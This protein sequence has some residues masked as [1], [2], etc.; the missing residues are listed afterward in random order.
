MKNL[1]LA[2]LV[3]STMTQSDYN[4]EVSAIVDRQNQEAYKQAQDN[5]LDNQKQASAYS[6]CPNCPKS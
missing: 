4:N 1:I 6:N 2:V 3:A 5:I